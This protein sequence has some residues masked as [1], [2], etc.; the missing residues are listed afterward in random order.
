M[1]SCFIYQF[2]NLLLFTHAKIASSWC[3]LNFISNDYENIL[4]TS[5]KIDNN[6]N[7]HY[8]SD[9]ELHNE[10]YCQTIKNIWNS[11]NETNTRDVIF[12]YRNPFEH[13]ISA[14]IQDFFIGS[15]KI[16]KINVILNNIEYDEI[17]K[18]KF[19]KSYKKNHY[20]FNKK[21]LVKFPTICKIILQNVFEYRMKFF[22]MESGHFS[23]WMDFVD[24]ISKSNKLKNS[25]IKYIDIYSN[26]LEKV[27]KPY[28]NKKE[29]DT[30]IYS[31]NFIF[32]IMSEVI[33]ESKYKNY[34]HTNL[35]KEMS[36]YNKIKNNE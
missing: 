8:N 25:K 16:K 15:D 11:F 19:W 32:D 22:E 24:K 23:F 29:D 2:D 35:E 20:E 30:E 1:Q 6:F 21:I 13:F 10:Q 4:N 31:Y 5:F 9:G 14:F 18:N 34:I 33:N 3:K 7:L 27:L 17:Q 12:L 28:L 36:I 26:N